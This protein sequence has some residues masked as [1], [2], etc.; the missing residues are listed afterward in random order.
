[1]KATTAGTNISASRMPRP[2]F[3]RP[4][5]CLPRTGEGDEAGCGSAKATEISGNVASV[6]GT[7]AVRRATSISG[8]APR[9]S[10][11]R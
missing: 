1:M 2:P 8:A 6:A 11:A 4:N 10:D 5:R 3:R 9:G 7:S